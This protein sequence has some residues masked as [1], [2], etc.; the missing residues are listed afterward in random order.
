M[1]TKTTKLSNSAQEESDIEALR[2]KLAAVT[3]ELTDARKDLES[4]QA[5]LETVQ[6]SLTESRLELQ[7]TKEALAT[8]EH[9]CQAANIELEEANRHRVH[10]R[11]DEQREEV[12]VV[13]RFRQPKQLPDGK[14]LSYHFLARQRKAIDKVIE[15]YKA[16]HPELDAVEIEE[17]RVDP[18]P[19]AQN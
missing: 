4:A 13:L 8:S 1:T 18:T 17:L 14:W 6:S 19:R 10:P 5:E 7:N 9:A 3:L 11:P 16:K 15:N 12:F 2:R